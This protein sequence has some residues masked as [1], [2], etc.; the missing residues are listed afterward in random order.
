MSRTWYW[1]TFNCIISRNIDAKMHHPVEYVSNSGCAN[2]RHSILQEVQWITQICFFCILIA[3]G[4]KTYFVILEYIKGKLLIY[5]S[6]IFRMLWLISTI[7]YIDIFIAK[8]YTDYY[9]IVIF[10]FSFILRL[11]LQFH[12]DR[13]HKSVARAVL[14]KESIHVSR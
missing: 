9:K 11:L 13:R 3:D 1:V 4:C 7:Y 2:S 14:T 12:P 5:W 8:A 6:L 10:Y